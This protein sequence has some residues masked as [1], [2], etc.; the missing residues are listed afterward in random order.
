MKRLQNRRTM[1]EYAQKKNQIDE[2]QIGR[3]KVLA[4]RL[5]DRLVGGSR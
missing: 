1:A 2:L 4:D 5:A 3:F